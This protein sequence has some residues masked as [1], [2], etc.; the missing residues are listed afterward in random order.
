[1]R[2][3]PLLVFT[4]VV[5]VVLA[6]AF[7]VGSAHTYAMRQEWYRHIALEIVSTNGLQDVAPINPKF[8]PALSNFA[9]TGAGP[10]KIRGGD[11]A[12][13]LGDGTA[14]ANVILKNG[15]GELLGVRF[16]RD[17]SNQDCVIGL[18][19]PNRQ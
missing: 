13:P 11:V 9:L 16:G 1:M 12:R 19:T 8:Q 3:K 15:K 14:V 17:S 10:V 2:P 7:A 4:A 6:L 5:L 18:W